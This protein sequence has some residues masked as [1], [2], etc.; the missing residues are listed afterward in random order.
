MV[1]TKTEALLLF[2]CVS[3]ATAPM[4]CVALV[5]FFF[6]QVVAQEETLLQVARGLSS[7]VI[8]MV[9]MPIVELA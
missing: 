3:V 4:E 5:I 9:A 6:C 2:P 8:V 7:A 1:V